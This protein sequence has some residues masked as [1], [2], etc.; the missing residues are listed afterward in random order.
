M[1]HY[2][3]D[4]HVVR[5]SIDCI[6]NR[7]RVAEREA[8]VSLTLETFHILVSHK[9]QHGTPTSTSHLDALTSLS[10]HHFLPENVAVIKCPIGL[11]KP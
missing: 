10:Y 3:L 1:F 2:K 7:S 9:A 11:S 8:S 6:L 5:V 4:A